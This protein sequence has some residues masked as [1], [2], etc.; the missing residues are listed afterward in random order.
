ML[1]TVGK[2]P[3]VTCL[4]P[5]LRPPSLRRQCQPIPAHQ[6]VR[7]EAGVSPLGKKNGQ[8]SWDKAAREGGGG[9]WPSQRL[10]G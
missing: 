1:A 9:H 4:C 2:P 3:P 10:T 6:C 8:N 7:D 5:T